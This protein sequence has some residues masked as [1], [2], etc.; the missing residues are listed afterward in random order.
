MIEPAAH[1]LFSVLTDGLLPAK[2]D[3]ELVSK[4]ILKQPARYNARVEHHYSNLGFII[5][6][7]ILESLTHSTW[8]KLIQKYLFKPL[9]MSSCGFG[10]TSILNNTIP[11][12]TWGHKLYNN[13][14]Y[15]IHGDNPEYFAPAGNIHCSLYDWAKYLTI[16][17]KASQGEI[18]L[19]NANSFQKL[20]QLYPSE[21]SEYTFGGWAKIKQSWTNGYALVHSGT[22]TYNYARVWVLPGHNAILMTT[23]NISKMSG[24]NATNK[25][26]IA[27]AEL[28]LNK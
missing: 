16:H 6:G 12:N 26:I 15:P 20:H 7:H 18:T 5:A 23:S 24:A 19:L 8:E 4:F 11:E 25:A 1:N 14:F 2:K 21:G 22:N 10:E 13:V 17:L 3:R 9:N 28:Y 27:L